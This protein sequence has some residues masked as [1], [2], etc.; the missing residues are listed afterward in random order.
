MRRRRLRDRRNGR[1]GRRSRGPGRN[2]RPGWRRSGPC[3]R[4]CQR[5]H[6]TRRRGRSR[7]GHGWRRGR[8]PLGNRRRGRPRGRYGLLDR[9]RWRRRLRRCSRQRSPAEA[10]EFAP[11]GERLV[12]LRAHHLRDNRRGRGAWSRRCGV[13]RG[14]QRFSA[15]GTRRQGRRVHIPA[16]DAPHVTDSSLFVCLSGHGGCSFRFFSASPGAV[17]TYSGQFTQAPQRVDNVQLKCGAHDL[18]ELERH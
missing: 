14:V 3:H 10:A 8:R 11:G 18:V 16:G 2:R 1:G 17:P 5:S 15:A 13:R 4:R 7:P 6:R 12:A 9:C